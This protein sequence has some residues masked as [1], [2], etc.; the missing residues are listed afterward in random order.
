MKIKDIV[1]EDTSSGET[2][3]QA[4]KLGLVNGKAKLL[5]KTA[6]KNSDPNTLFN[7]GLAEG[8]SKD[9]DEKFVT[10]TITHFAKKYGI[11]PTI[12]LAVWRSEGGMDWQSKL[13][14]KSKK[15]KT[16]GGKEA[17]Y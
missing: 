4:K 14:P 6:A 3:R 15:V 8:Y 17:S 12:A 1:Q 5:H 16:D 10:D 11:S 9:V 7:L 13:K 2:M